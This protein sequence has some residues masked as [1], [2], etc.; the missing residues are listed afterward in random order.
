MTKLHDLLI[1][2][3][4]FFHRAEELRGDRHDL[5]NIA[6]QVLNKSASNRLISKQECMVLLG[7]LD[8]VTCSETIESVSLTLSAK[9]VVVGQTQTPLESLLGN[10]DYFLLVLTYGEITARSY[11][12]RGFSSL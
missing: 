5:V 7:G 3:I 11:W 2:E 12:L 8:L 4:V 10:Y 1:F 9:V 6:K